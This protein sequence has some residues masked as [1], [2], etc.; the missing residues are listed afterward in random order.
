MKS[1]AEDFSLI[2]LSEIFHFQNQATLT[3]V[4]FLVFFFFPKKQTAKIN[5][6][7]QMT[8]FFSISFKYFLQH[9]A[10][11][12]GRQSMFDKTVL[13]FPANLV[14]ISMEVL[15]K[16]YALPLQSLFI[17]SDTCLMVPEHD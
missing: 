8:F 4:V 13:T 1:N 2:L 11:E 3:L 10:A 9:T 6:C 14:S 7:S 15:P 5:S 16:L 12:T 17:S